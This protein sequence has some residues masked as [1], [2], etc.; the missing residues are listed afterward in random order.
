MIRKA[1]GVFNED[2]R[3]LNRKN[4]TLKIIE[5]NQVSRE[6]GNWIFMT[7]G[8]AVE[9]VKS[10]VQ[11]LASSTTA[12]NIL[13][14]TAYDNLNQVKGRVGLNSWSS[15]TNLC[16]GDEARTEMPNYS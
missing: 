1:F 14:R 7:K 8:Q 2:C 15:R 9:Y 5:I 12:L 16:S 10:V 6:L 13:A 4:K 3:D 11:E